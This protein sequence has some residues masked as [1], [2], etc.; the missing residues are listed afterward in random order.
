MH[1][2]T[3]GRL[4]LQNAE[5]SRPKPLLLLVYLA[6]EGAKPRRFLGELFWPTASK[7]A[8]SI[9]VA[10]RQIRKDAP[11]ALQ[12]DEMRLWCNLPCDVYELEEL[13]RSKQLEQAFELYSGPFLEGAELPHWSIE[14]EEWVYSK[15][16]FLATLMREAALELAERA[17]GKGY[18][19]TSA[20]WAEQAIQ[21][22]EAPEPQ[23]EFWLRVHPLLLA[24]NSPL[25]E[26]VKQKANEWDLKLELSPQTAQNRLKQTFVGRQ[27][28]LERLKMLEFGAWAWI[29]AKSGLGKTSLLQQLEGI[30]L[31]ARSGLP[32]ATL[33]P[34]LGQNVEYSE[35]H[36]LLRQLSQKTGT[37]LLDGWEQMDSESQQLLKKL[38]TLGTQARIL[39]T[40]DQEAPFPIQERLE[41]A[42]LTAAELAK[43]PGAFEDTA[44][45]PSLLGAWLRNESIQTALETQLSTLPEV[46][47]QVYYALALLETPDPSL[48]RQALGLS[49]PVLAEALEYLL[50]L[51]L[52]E[53][54]GQ[55][56]GQSAVRQILVNR[57]MLEAKLALNLA[58]VSSQAT[59]LPLFQKAKALWEESDLS[60]I[61]QAYYSWATETL[62]RGFP[63]QAAENLAHA[64]SMPN[65]IL[66]RAKALERS[67]QYKESLE[68]LTPLP[69]THEV[70]ALKSALYRRL[71]DPEQARTCAEIALESDG[72][73]RAEALNTLANL[74]YQQGEF[75]EAEKLYRRTA[76]LWLTLGENARWIGALNNRALALLSAGHDPEPVLKE[77]LGA[78][79]DH[80]AIKAKTMMNLGLAKEK[81]QDLK[82]AKEAYQ[83]AARLAEEAGALSSAARSWSNLGAFFHR[84]DQKEQTQHA[85]QK[86]LHLAQQV[87]EKVLLGTI[88][89][90]LAELNEDF[91][92]FEE[93]LR[94][95]ELSGDT[96]TLARYQAE[97]QAFISR[98]PNNLHT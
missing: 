64:P 19:D 94:L 79:D 91:E 23:P 82:G 20:N 24:G 32:Y 22:D 29:S 68:L 12:D 1:L 58:R 77:A 70:L 4:E 39:I 57:P 88:L 54:S 18:F 47:Q 30:Y 87:G 71:G 76:T 62:K 95:F 49:A 96:A 80:L 26:L 44:G 85:Y 17:A 7:P 41:L 21:M 35:E 43:Y 61:E 9:A 53:P 84:L 73:A 14:L 48:V 78:A 90:N 63:M 28:E 27:A 33:E 74:K 51:G 5:L 67:G 52:I 89:A 31:P 2:C 75:E 56:R 83:Q 36:I 81:K 72:E 60:K 8:N 38:Q 65:L 69:E 93:A 37:W 46:V 11:E 86:A 13:L 15:R 55:V 34:L 40:S 92:A 98:S 42:A 10:V 6:L 16:E 25:I 97:Y 66:L 3:L 50:D 45:I 59:S